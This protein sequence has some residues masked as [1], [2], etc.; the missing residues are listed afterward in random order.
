MRT[1]QLTSLLR[2]TRNAV[3]SRIRTYPQFVPNGPYA[4]CDR[5]VSALRLCHVPDSLRIGE[6][7]LRSLQTL[8]SHSDNNDMH[9]VMAGRLNHVQ[10]NIPR[11]LAVLP[12]HDDFKDLVQ[13][14]RQRRQ[15]RSSSQSHP[16][17]SSL[18]RSGQVYHGRI[19]A[20]IEKTRFQSNRS[21]SSSAKSS[22][23]LAN[24][25][26]T[27]REA[28]QSPRKAARYSIQLGRAFVDWVKHMWA[29]AKLLAAD[30]RVSSKILRKITTGKQISRRERNFIVKTGVDLARLVPF[31]LFLIIPLAEF[32]LPFALRLFPNMLP[33]QFQDQMKSEEN[34]KRRLKGRLELAKYLRDVVEEKAK[35]IKASDAHSE[36]KKEATDLTDFLDAIRS[37]KYVDASEVARFARFFN[38][39]LTI[40]GAVRPQLVAMCKYMGISPYGHDLFLRFKLRSKL[41]AIKK[42]DME[43]MWEGGVESLTDEE[44]AKACGER[45]IREVDVRLMRRE[46]SD[47]LDLSQS[48]EIPGSLLIMSR[49]LLYT[50]DSEYKEKTDSEGLVET[51]GSLP[52]D[53]I[54]DVKKAADVGDATNAERLEETLRQAQLIAMESQREAQKEKEDEEKRKKKEAEEE[55]EKVAAESQEDAPTIPDDTIS[56]KEV[57]EKVRVQEQKLAEAIMGTEKVGTESVLESNAAEEAVEEIER[58]EEAEQKERDGIREMLESLEALASD[59]AVEREREELHNLKME[60]AMAEDSLRGAEG[61]ETSDF[62]RL[63]RL[64]SRLERE[65]ERVDTKVGLRMKLLDKD[66][67]GLMS[68]EECKGVVKIISGE[69]DDDVVEET[70]QRLDADDDGN[71]SREDLKRVL[72]EMQY[73]LGSSQ[74]SSQK[75]QGTSLESE[76][77]SEANANQ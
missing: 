61:E 15:F 24:G 42:D 66:N 12:N 27:W 41:N 63:K 73:D 52:D 16:S 74:E 10:N 2:V 55:A 9:C 33:S 35:T 30:V 23:D 20:G 39:E 5:S 67:D 75:K 32:A 7:G 26:V 14:P 29:G 77:P 8:N 68:L 44:V 34:L 60:L 70:L 22:G 4:S 3:S 50:T 45:G 18:R 13:T 54:M 46:L 56:D 76:R 1:V 19:Q 69:R 38:D 36:L 31:S 21:F 37:G 51:L 71:I 58:D 72:K 17:A 53:V 6:K 28:L 43:I 49:A 59:S 40:D 48:K 64:V 47:W 25:R 65:I 57:M 62:R 11:V